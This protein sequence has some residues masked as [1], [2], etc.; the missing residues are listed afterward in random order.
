MS[1]LDI[2]AN[3][4]AALM[5]ASLILAV[6]HEICI[7]LRDKDNAPPVP[8]PALITWAERRRQQRSG[9]ESRQRAT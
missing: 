4:F 2:F 8:S 5:S 6:C 1:I 7:E 9:D 3:V